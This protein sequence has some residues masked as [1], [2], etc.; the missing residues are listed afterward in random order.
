MC[1]EMR[2]SVGVLC[3]RRGRR[4]PQQRVCRV[5]QRHMCT[6]YLVELGDDGVGGV[7]DDGAEHAGDVSGRERHHQLLALRA[8]L[9]G[10]RHH[11]LELYSGTN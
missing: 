10:F 1:V 3:D 8:L 2:Y 5:L 9:A 6:R 7:R 4:E 11:K